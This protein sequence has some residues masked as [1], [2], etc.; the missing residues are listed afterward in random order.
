VIIR[1]V[2]DDSRGWNLARVIW[3][4][5]RGFTSERNR[6]YLQRAGGHYIVGESCAPT[7]RKPA[8]RSRARAAT[9]RLRATYGSSRF[10]STMAPTATGS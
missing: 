9:T 6:R 3:V 1:K 2:K 5:D 10:G 8:R 4:I 7:A